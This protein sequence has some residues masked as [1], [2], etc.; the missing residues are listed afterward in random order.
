M[1]MVIFANAELESLDLNSDS[2]VSC[3]EVSMHH[4]QK[5]ATA[6][7][8]ITFSL[9]VTRLPAW[10]STIKEKGSQL[11]KITDAFT[12]LSPEEWKTILLASGL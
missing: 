12:G 8:S 1:H 11:F 4:L 9:F 7:A 10:H 3:P 5:A 2:G 6:I